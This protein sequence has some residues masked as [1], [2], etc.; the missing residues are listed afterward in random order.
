MSLTIWCNGK[1]SDEAT[2][3]LME[4]LR[5]H[6]LVFS[7][8]INA[9]V[10]AASARDVD[11]GEAEV[12]FGQPDVR[13]CLEQRRL[14]WI[15]VT[16]AGYTRYDTPEFREALRERGTVFTNMSSVF[17]DPC[18]Q[19]ALAMMLGLAR[20]LP[21]S[22]RDQ[23]TDRSWHYDERRYDSRLLTGQTVLMLGFGAIGRRLAELLAPF[24]MKLYAVRR[25]VRSEAGVHIISEEKISAVLPLA[26]HV[27]NILPDNDATLNY[28]NARRLACLR[29]SAKF[30]N[31]G[32]GTTVDQ[33][34]LIDALQSRR[35]AAA[36]LDVTDPEP[37]P[38]THPLWTAPNCFIT[39]HT[40]G[41]RHDQDEALVK[42][43]LANLGAF[44]RGEAMTDRV[45]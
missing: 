16:T 21:Q 7:K 10:H 17:A 34:A 28:V 1:F 30:Y 32:R 36:Y 4:G 42:T 25:S 9:N 41:G 37:L 14:R 45:G 11:I 39:P 22:H 23:L 26:D 38:P 12:A 13:D 40:A 6:R 19:H 31:V 44:E 20:Q 43:F 2:R 3:R 8:A 35:L 24:G 29:P 5:G 33:A 15:A 27:V 18:A